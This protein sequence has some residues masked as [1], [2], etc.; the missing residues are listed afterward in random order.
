VFVG[1]GVAVAG[2]GVAV[3]VGGKVGVGK[4]V[5]VAVGPASGS[6]PKSGVVVASSATLGPSIPA[7]NES[8]LCH[9]SK[10]LA[11]MQPTHTRISNTRPPTTTGTTGSLRR[12][13]DTGGTG[14]VSGRSVSAFALSTDF[15]GTGGV[16]IGD[17]G[18]AGLTGASNPRAGVSG[19]SATASGGV[20]GAS[21]DDPAGS[22]DDTSL[23]AARPAATSEDS[24][25][26]NGVSTGDGSTVSVS[27]TVDSTGRSGGSGGSDDSSVL[28]PVFS[29]T[30]G[31]GGDS[32]TSSAV[33][34]KFTGASET[35]FGTAGIA[36]GVSRVG[37]PGESSAFLIVSDASDFCRGVT[38]TESGSRRLTGLGGT[39]GLRGLG[40]LG[41]T[42]EAVGLGGS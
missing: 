41:G 17:D 15:T 9:T 11:P 42:L 39:R 22:A 13:G 2:T 18:S 34:S 12:S 6:I 27:A 25:G 31:S 20:R 32:T 28:S 29:S 30:G 36:G 8:S 19:G 38:G 23:A 37:G 4:G 26:D 24:S 33:S 21:P 10:L 3:L 14:A 40:G 35:S 1:K 5:L 7:S 16:A